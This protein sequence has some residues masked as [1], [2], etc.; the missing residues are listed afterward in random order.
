VGLE[1]PFLAALLSH[2]KK[3]FGWLMLRSLSGREAR[4]VLHAVS[5]S[6]DSESNLNF[7][8]L[9]DLD[10]SPDSANH[11]RDVLTAIAYTIRARRGQLLITSQ[12]RVP[13]SVAQMLDADPICE[14]KTCQT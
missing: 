9:D 12:R 8:V 3:N 1:R 11:Y 7:V 13:A 5:Q 4:A 10:L 2:N 14:F 6:I